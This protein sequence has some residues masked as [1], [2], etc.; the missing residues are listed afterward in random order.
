M[1]KG[2]RYVSSTEPRQIKDSL[3]H[4]RVKGEIKGKTEDRRVLDAPAG[5][6]HH[7]CCSTFLHLQLLEAEVLQASSE[8][9]FSPV[10]QGTNWN[11]E[12]LRS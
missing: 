4:A 7:G 1:F 9:P 10:E 3:L 5:R 11:L 12:L 2:Q 8:P 6:S